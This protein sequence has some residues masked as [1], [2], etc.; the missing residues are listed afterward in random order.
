MK[1]DWKREVLSHFPRAYFEWDCS[2]EDSICLVGFKTNSGVF[3]VLGQ[4]DDPN[5]AWFEA[6]MNTREL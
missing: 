4:G 5:E 6:Y 1:T 2:N 3:S